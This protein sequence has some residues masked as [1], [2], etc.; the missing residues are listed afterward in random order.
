MRRYKCNEIEKY[1]MSNKQLINIAV[2]QKNY[3]ALKRLGEAG[4]SFNDVI[5]EILKKK[6]AQTSQQL[7]RLGLSAPIQTKVI[8]EDDS[9]HG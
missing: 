8:R 5:S 9:S 2:S 7:G 3:L 4:D 6:L 1:C